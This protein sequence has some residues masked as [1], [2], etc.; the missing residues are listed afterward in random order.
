MDAA[1]GKLTDVHEYMVAATEA[2]LA[3]DLT[4]AVRNKAVDAFNQIMQMGV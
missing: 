4:F 1:L 2:S 3:T